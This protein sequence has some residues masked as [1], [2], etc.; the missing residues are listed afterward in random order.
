M[1]Y[2]KLSAEAKKKIHAVVVKEFQGI[3][4][5][6]DNLGELKSSVLSY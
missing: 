2:P 3:D 5:L 1:T 6:S 4:D